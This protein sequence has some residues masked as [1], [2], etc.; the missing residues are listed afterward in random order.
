MARKVEYIVIDGCIQ[1]GRKV[2]VKGEL[3]S[4]ASKEQAEELVGEGK[5]ALLSDPIARLLLAGASNAESEE[6]E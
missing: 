1:D 4:P 5:I 3:Y 6:D 2:T